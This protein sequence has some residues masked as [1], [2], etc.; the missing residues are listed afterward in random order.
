MDLAILIPGISLFLFL[1]VWLD[2]KFKDVHD[3][4]GQ[5]DTADKVLAE[6]VDGINQRMDR[7]EMRM[8]RL[9]VKMDE[10]FTALGNKIDR[11]I[12]GL[13]EKSAA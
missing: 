8:D 12:L 1:I 13:A 11:L 7:L 10:G 9:E 5:H 6:R 3:K 4:L 2:R